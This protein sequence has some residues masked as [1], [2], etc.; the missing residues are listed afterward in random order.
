MTV[1]GSKNVFFFGAS[2]WSGIG[3]SLGE[4]LDDGVGVLAFCKFAY[5]ELRGWPYL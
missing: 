4:D 5:M 2:P 1:G 3:L